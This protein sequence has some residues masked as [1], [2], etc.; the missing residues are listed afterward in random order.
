M[1]CLINYEVAHLSILYFYNFPCQSPGLINTLE[2]LGFSPLLL[3]HSVCLSYIHLGPFPQRKSRNNKNQGVTNL[4][5][6][7]QKKA[8]NL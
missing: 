1:G 8:F 7:F 3:Y 4:V 6:Y 5:K 2:N